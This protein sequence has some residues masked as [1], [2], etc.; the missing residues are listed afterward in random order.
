MAGSVVD[1]SG[2]GVGVADVSGAA[3]DVSGAADDAGGAAEEGEAAPV[4]LACRFSPWWMYWLM[5]SMW[6]SSRLNADEH[7][8][9][10]KRATKSHSF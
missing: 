3:E 9:R 5:P 6:M 7:A 10:E 4:P 8:L 2:V 1:S